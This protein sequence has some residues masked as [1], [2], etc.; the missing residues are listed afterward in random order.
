M[1][2][3]KVNKLIKDHYNGNPW[4]DTTIAATLK[5]LT[6]KQAAAKTGGLNSIWQIV[7]HMILWRTALIGR[8]MDQPIVYPDNNYIEE[9]KNTSAAAW[10]ETIKKFERSQKEIT[11]FLAGS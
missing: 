11:S 9:V 8:V 5:Q 3:E 6:A 2:I 1:D 7:N 4:I 10:K